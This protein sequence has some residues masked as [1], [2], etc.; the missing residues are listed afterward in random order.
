MFIRSGH[1]GFH[2]LSGE[3]YSRSNALENP[4]TA[5]R[6]ASS[7]AGIPS[8]LPALAGSILSNQNGKGILLVVAGAQNL[9]SM[10]LKPEKAL[11]KRL[12]YH[13]NTTLYHGR[14]A[15]KARITKE[16][17][18]PEASECFSRETGTLHVAQRPGLPRL[19]DLPAM[20]QGRNFSPLNKEWALTRP[21]K[22]YITTIVVVLAIIA[23]L[24]VIIFSS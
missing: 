5:A 7:P 15:N 1:C 22:G 2:S 17:A 23:V 19:H 13:G 12:L 10:Q 24:A 18:M 8:R 3:R 9:V 21:Q 20:R 11:G 4:S 6:L 14:T 16:K